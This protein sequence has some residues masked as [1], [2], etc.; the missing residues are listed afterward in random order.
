MSLASGDVLLLCS[1]GLSDLG[2]DVRIAD[3][4]AAH[5][6]PSTMAQALI[7]AALDAGGR[8]NVTVALARP[9]LDFRGD[10]N[11]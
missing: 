3:V 9:P 2:S 8:D 10:E 4:L 11:E 5:N 6:D 1:D 7:D